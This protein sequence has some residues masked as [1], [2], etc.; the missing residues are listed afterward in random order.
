M[1]TKGGIYET[2]VFTMITGDF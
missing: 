1:N 2:V